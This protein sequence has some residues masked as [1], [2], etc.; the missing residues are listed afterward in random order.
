[1]ATLS[2][3]PC[4]VLL[5]LPKSISEF[6]PFCIARLAAL[7]FLSEPTPFGVCTKLT[8]WYNTASS[9]VSGSLWNAISNLASSSIDQEISG[10]GLLP[11]FA[12]RDT[13][14][15]YRKAFSSQLHNLRQSLLTSDFC[16]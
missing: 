15:L 6:S 3:E 13:H 12:C 2:P 5:G 9:I 8:T 4:K 14:E 16:D 7:N 1:M 10:Q 11:W